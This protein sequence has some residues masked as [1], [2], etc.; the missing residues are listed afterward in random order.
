MGTSD[1]IRSSRGTIARMIVSMLTVSSSMTLYTQMHPFMHTCD[2][3]YV[4]NA[5]S[6][7][8]VCHNF[9]FCNDT[10]VIGEIDNMCECEDTCETDISQFGQLEC[11]YDIES[12]RDIQRCATSG[13]PHAFEDTTGLDNGRGYPHGGASCIHSAYGSEYVETKASTE[14]DATRRVTG[15][16]NSSKYLVYDLDTQSDSAESVTPGASMTC[17]QSKLQVCEARFGGAEVRDLSFGDSTRVG[18]VLGDLGARTPTR[19]RTLGPS[20]G[21]INRP[22]SQSFPFMSA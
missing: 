20:E 8:R 13:H 21:V 12:T 2:R 10:S 22:R 7:H 1:A 5:R 14:A 17:M 6:K 3:D 9:D 18:F 16:A 4:C 15:G 19:Q 11:S